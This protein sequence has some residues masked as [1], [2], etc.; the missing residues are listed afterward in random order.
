MNEYLIKMGPV[1]T[2]GRGEPIGWRL[3]YFGSQFRAVLPANG[4]GPTCWHTTPEAAI[5]CLEKRISESYHV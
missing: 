2:P 4:W 5:D 3:T 1:S